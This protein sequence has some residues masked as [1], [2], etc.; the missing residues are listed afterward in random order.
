MLIFKTCPQAINNLLL[1]IFLT[2]KYISYLK[3]ILLNIVTIKFYRFM[4]FIHF[5]ALNIYVNIHTTYYNKK[6]LELFNAKNN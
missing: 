6:T 5:I 2:K 3:I 4:F 1:N